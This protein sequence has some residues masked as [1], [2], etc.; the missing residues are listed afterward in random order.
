MDA[1]NSDTLTPLQRSSLKKKQ[2]QSKLKEWIKTL[3]GKEHVARCQRELEQHKDVPI[4]IAVIGQSRTGKST[5]INK[6]RGFLDERGRPLNRQSPHY[7]PVGLTQ[8]TLSVKEYTFE[9]NDSIKLVDLPGAGTPEFPINEYEEMMNFKQYDAFIIITA[10]TFYETD[11]IISKKIKKLQK[12]YFFARTKIDIDLQ[13]YEEEMQEDFTID[14]WNEECETKI[15]KECINNLNDQEHDVYLLSKM[16]YKKVELEDGSNCLVEF[17]DNQRLLTDILESL[18]EIQS[19][20]LLFQL[21][22]SFEAVILLKSNALHKRIWKVA[23]TSASGAAIPLPGTSLGI[24]M[25]LFT[26][27]INFQKRQLGLDNGSLKRNANLINKKPDEF[28]E[29][30]VERLTQPSSPGM[31]T[32]SLGKFYK[33]CLS[34]GGDSKT[35]YTQCLAMAPTMLVQGAA[36]GGVAIASEAIETGLKIAIPV[37]GSLICSAIS[38]CSTYRILHGMLQTHYKIALACNEVVKDHI[39]ADDEKMRRRSKTCLF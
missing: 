31:A 18:D 3:D 16:N 37:V 34:N 6:F 10:N 28:I 38:G 25:C 29:M 30:V 8:T 17:K 1:Y 27:E 33:A 36:L 35:I 39:I 13:S 5:F 4:K 23:L 32:H 24:D 19:T 7:A 12:P 11:M 2:D 22:S 14:A 20:S 21:R 26:Y 9:D 15:K